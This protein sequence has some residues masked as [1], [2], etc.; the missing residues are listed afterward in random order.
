MRSDLISEQIFFN[1][2]H[3]FLYL[4]I[5]Q[6]FPCWDTSAYVPFVQPLLTA[7]R[8]HTH[9]HVIE[10]LVWRTLP[11]WNI[12]TENLNTLYRFFSLW[13]WYD[14]KPEFKPAGQWEV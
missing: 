14:L 7:L 2:V 11:P 10:K 8:A 9:K 4:L 12:L 1:N 5:I 6:L 3:L 13:Y